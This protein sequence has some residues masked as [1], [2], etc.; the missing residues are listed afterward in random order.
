MVSARRLRGRDHLL[1][2]GGRLMPLVVLPILMMSATA[3]AFGAFALV[4]AAL[5]HGALRQ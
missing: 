2:L 1:H 5:V 3:V 4:G